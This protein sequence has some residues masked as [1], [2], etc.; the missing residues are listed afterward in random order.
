LVF[1][2]GLILNTLLLLFGVANRFALEA[3][4]INKKCFL[5]FV[6]KFNFEESF[7]LC[8]VFVFCFLLKK[9]STDFAFRIS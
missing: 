5:I 1:R 3:E 9:K 2:K 7:L 8:K 6:L 4:K